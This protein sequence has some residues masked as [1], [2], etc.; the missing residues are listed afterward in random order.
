MAVTSCFVVYVY[1]S[2]ELPQM[3]EALQAK[4]VREI[5]CGSNQSAA[6]TSNGELYTWGS[7]ED[8]CLGHGDTS[9]QLKPKQ[10]REIQSTEHLYNLT[11]AA[12]KKFSTLNVV[13]LIGCWT[14]G[15]SCHL[16]CLR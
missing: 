1:R 14:T 10:V 4:H 11:F 3:V 9:N 5:T 7:G 12:P 8:G 16:C 15:L 13:F 6:I 2:L